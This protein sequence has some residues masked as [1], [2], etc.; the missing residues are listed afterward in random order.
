MFF[1]LARFVSCCLMHRTNGKTVP[2]RAKNERTGGG[3]PIGEKRLRFN[4]VGLGLGLLPERWA[5]G[6]LR[7][8]QEC[9]KGCGDG[10]GWMKTPGFA[11]GSSRS[12]CYGCLC[13]CG[14]KRG[15][16]EP[17]TFE[18]LVVRTVSKGPGDGERRW[19]WGW[20]LV[21]SRQGRASM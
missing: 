4:A 17:I 21:V 13:C 11:V 3:R 7:A 6:S 9:R 8:G 14:G 10:R 12:A 20:G 16:V 2:S 5:W 15:E 18:R 1:H 19:G